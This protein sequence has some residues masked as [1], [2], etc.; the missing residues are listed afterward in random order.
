MANRVKGIT[1][2]IG[3]DVTGLDKALKKVNSNIRD[4]QAQL[5]DVNKLLK[6]DPTNTELLQQ[7]QRLLA[8]AIN[9]TKNKLDT[10]KEAEKQV[11]QQFERG[12][13][14]QAQYEALQREIIATEGALSNLEAEAEQTNAELAKVGN[15]VQEV[16]QK[17]GDFAAKTKNISR[18]AAGAL[19]GIAGM[20]V[21]AAAA[22]DDLN[23]LAKQTGLSTATLQKA[24]YA[25]DLIDVS[26]E[27]FTG[28]I[29][30]MVGRLRTNEDAF[31]ALGV[32]TRDAGGALLSN[33]EIFFNSAEALSKM[34]NETER[35]IAAQ[36]L[37]GKSAAELAGILDD[38]GK[39]LKQYGDEAEQL[40][41]ILDQETLDSLNEVND[42]IDILKAKATA[43]FGKAAASALQALTP[44]IESIAASVG[45]LLE[46][47]A[48]MGPAQLELILKILA[49]VA[50]IS[51]VAG[52]ISKIGGA[53]TTL[54]PVISALN[55]LVLANPIILVITAIV[56]AVGAATVYIVNHW[57]EIRTDLGRMWDNIKAFWEKV[58]GVFEN[59]KNKIADVVSTV[60][61]K[62]N[63]VVTFIKELPQRALTWGRDLIQNFIQGI[64][65][66]FNALRDTL[67]NAAQTVKDFLGFS[68]PD[69]GPLSNFHTYAPDMMELFAKGIKDNEDLI[70][71]Q[72]TKSLQFAPAALQM[73]GTVNAQSGYTA[74][75]VAVGASSTVNIYPQQLDNSTM[76]YILMRV[77]A[78]LGAM[79]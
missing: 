59:I 23:T 41:L 18:A 15:V 69:K 47:I 72:F 76:D 60:K 35:D 2:E 67:H 25:A 53:I 14:S 77:N 5:K 9:E 79:A 40:G 48:T 28:S 44:V 57:E 3:G 34:S 4:T 65:D 22:A 42:T 11:Q 36:E 66:K 75:P 13:V 64:K 56:A 63:E 6:L 1:V 73:A 33:E 51:P 78:G 12:E 49:A 8:D 21:K 54:M 61:N 27:T 10:L 43:S 50:L 55:A 45:Q 62:F 68:E 16:S 7:K 37:F 26:Y 46:K 38:G 19:V 74:A 20:G 52:M 31:A 29:N 70:A 39:A 58:K 71:N 32:A 30:K 24:K 17:A